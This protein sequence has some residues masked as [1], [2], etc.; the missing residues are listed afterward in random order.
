[1][2]VSVSVFVFVFVGGER[3]RARFAWEPEK[4]AE[5]SPVCPDFATRL[6]TRQPRHAGRKPPSNTNTDTLTLAGR[7]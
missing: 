7:P 1:V 2:G 3:S 5:M 4:G 6:R